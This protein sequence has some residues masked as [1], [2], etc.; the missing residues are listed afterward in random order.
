MDINKKRALVIP[1]RCASG[2]R[3]PGIWRAAAHNE[4]AL[5]IFHSPKACAHVAREMDLSEYYRA[6]KRRELLDHNYTAPLLSSNLRDE[7]SIFGGEEQLSGCIDHAMQN[8]AP[9]YIVIA[10]SC[11]AGTIGDDVAA[12]A[13]RASEKWGKPVLAVPSGGFL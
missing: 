7:H 6:A 3:M 12:V 1:K 2:C 9:Q 10:S 13:R 5:V 8:Y 11:V 4:G